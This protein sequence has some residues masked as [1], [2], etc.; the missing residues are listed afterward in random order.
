MDDDD[1]EEFPAPPTQDEVDA[2]NEMFNTI[3]VNNENITNLDDS[4]DAV[5]GIINVTIESNTQNNNVNIEEIPPEPT[6]I[7]S[8]PSAPQPVPPPRDSSKDYMRE[9]SKDES[10]LSWLEIINIAKMPNI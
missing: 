8:V 4:E 1:D 5:F 2:A 7:D 9:Y 10:N 6:E 3:A